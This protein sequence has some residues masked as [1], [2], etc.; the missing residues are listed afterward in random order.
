MTHTISFVRIG[1]LG[2]LLALIFI[3][4]PIHAYFT[5]AQSAEAL[6]GGVLFTIDYSFGMAKHDVY[7]PFFAQNQSFAP[8]TSTVSYTILDENDKEVKG[9]F[10]AIVLSNATLGTNGMYKVK[11]GGAKNLHLQ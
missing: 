7:L 5:T 9:K 6:T 11:K 1:F 4:T 8:S 2:A 10:S 3:A